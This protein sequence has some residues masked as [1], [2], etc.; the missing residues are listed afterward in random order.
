M[1]TMYRFRSIVLYGLPGV[2]ALIGYWSY[3]SKRRR[4]LNQQ[5]EEVIRVGVA[6]DVQKCSFQKAEGLDIQEVFL[7]SYGTNYATPVPGGSLYREELERGDMNPDYQDSKVVLDA[8]VAAA[9]L[10]LLGT[11]DLSTQRPDPEGKVAEGPWP[12]TNGSASQQGTEF[13]PCSPEELG[14]GPSCSPANVDL[15]ATE[16][17]DSLARSPSKLE[18]NKSLTPCTADTEETLPCSPI[19]L[20]A[21][22]QGLTEEIR[23]AVGD[24]N[25]RWCEGLDPS[26]GLVEEND[27]AG[28]EDRTDWEGSFNSSTLSAY[29][30][31]HPLAN[32]VEWEIEV[33]NHLVGRLIGKKGRSVNFLKRS[34]GAK[35]Y[36]FNATRE[37]QMCHIEGSKAQVDKA[38]SLIG[39]RFGDL[40]LTDRR[41]ILG[42]QL[43]PEA[44][45]K[46]PEG[47]M[48]GVI[49]AKAVSLTHVF[50]QW[51]ESTSQ[52]ALHS[53]EEQMMW[54]YSQHEASPLP[55]CVRLGE[56]CAAPGP[57]G[58][59]R[60]AQLRSFCGPNTVEIL[61]LD[62]GGYEK[63]G[64]S[65][66]RILRP[67][68][69][70]L[71]FQG[72]EVMLD[73]LGLPLGESQFSAEAALELEEMTKGVALLAKC[74]RYHKSGMPMVHIW[75]MVGDELV[76]LNHLL[77]QRGFAIWVE[78]C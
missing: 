13:K 47:E 25:S 6:T 77:V 67:D 64:I 31:N 54:C 62:H 50:V 78:T 57:T 66:L 41:L 38:L 45:M 59:W 51:N 63:V 19:C 42:H 60:R 52:Y 65:T 12:E 27:S 74:V 43:P 55:T 5:A 7:Q 2:L 29:P 23:G 58:G 40:D 75:K 21:D 36:V 56:L 35:I 16:K 76:S 20:L 39:G 53:L 44:W 49:V 9:E 70:S 30:P 4:W 73:S 72:I 22:E 24:A 18:R 61:Y 37:L 33:P 15:C 46:L 71:P 8:E 26:G 17:S 1:I 14:E 3:I 11:S 69:L 10:D 68:F 48:I 28:S 32:L 34:S